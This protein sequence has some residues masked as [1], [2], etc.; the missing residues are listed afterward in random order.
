MAMPGTYPTAGTDRLPLSQV[1]LIGGEPGT[2]LFPQRQGCIPEFAFR[3]GLDA[4]NHHP[5][6]TGNRNG[7]LVTHVTAPKPSIYAIFTRGSRTKPEVRPATRGASTYA[8]EVSLAGMLR[9]DAFNVYV[10][11]AT[12]EKFLVTPQA[13]P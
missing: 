13:L 7:H 2:A 4:A 8:R 6:F 12:G 3:T 5:W 1:A 11:R 10:K 9:P